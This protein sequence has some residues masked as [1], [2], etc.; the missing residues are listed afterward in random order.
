MIGI[1]RFAGLASGGHGLAVI[2]LAGPT[3]PSTPPSPTLACY[4]TR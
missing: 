1:T 2:A 3:A 4:P